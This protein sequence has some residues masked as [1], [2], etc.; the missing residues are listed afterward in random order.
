MQKNLLTKKEYPVIKGDA[1]SKDPV[2]NKNK[3]FLA[4][5]YFKHNAKGDV[6]FIKL[7]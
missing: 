6:C 4:F 5:S 1:D 7:P 2:F 3:N